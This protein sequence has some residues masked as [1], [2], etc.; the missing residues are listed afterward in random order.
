MS[1][2]VIKKQKKA[3]I[4]ARKPGKEEAILIASNSGSDSAQSGEGEARSN[5]ETQTALRGISLEKALRDNRIDSST[6]DVRFFIP[7]L[8]KTEVKYFQT[9][10]ISVTTISRLL[11]R[12]EGGPASGGMVAIP[13]VIFFMESELNKNK[14]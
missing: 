2:D 7:F 6:S 1:P 5:A 8:P 14:R 9:S 3:I 12:K 10:D 11:E 4:D 13:P